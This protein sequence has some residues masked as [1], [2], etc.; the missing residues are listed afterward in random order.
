MPG[1]LA[2]PR[3]WPH[4]AGC[5]SK[6]S[7]SASTRFALPLEF[8]DQAYA[9]SLGYAESR[10]NLS[11]LNFANDGVF[12]DGIALQMACISGTLAQGLTASLR[13]SIKV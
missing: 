1:A 7:A 13:V 8:C 12:G 4:S 5:W 6:N 11:R 10:R 3:P 9:Q 2:R